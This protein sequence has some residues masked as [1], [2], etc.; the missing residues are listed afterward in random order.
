LK[1]QKVTLQ[2]WF[3]EKYADAWEQVM[4]NR[5]F[6]TPTSSVRYSVGQPMGFYSSWAVFALTHHA[7]VEFAAHRKG[8]RSFRDYSLLGDDIV[9]WNRDVAIEYKKLLHELG[10]PFSKEKSLSSDDQTIRVEFAKRFFL[11]GEEITPLNPNIIK[12]ASKSIYDLLLLT[13]V[14]SGRGW[15]WKEADIHAPEFLSGKGKKLLVLLWHLL[16]VR[17]CP[18]FKGVT[19]NL[20]DRELIER[21][22]NKLRLKM[23]QRKLV[24]YQKI[25]ENP[26]A[27]EDILTSRGV[28]LSEELSKTFQEIDTPYP[29]VWVL[30]DIEQSLAELQGNLLY[31]EEGKEIS[32][33][34]ADVEFLPK[35]WIQTFY[36]SR[37]SEFRIRSSTWLTALL[38]LQKDQE[39]IRS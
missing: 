35:P 39:V 26:K 20:P 16:R 32:E 6:H 23:L 5:E 11:N 38:N 21:E 13:K 27:L 1:L 28:L 18:P 31:P 37:E 15:R 17:W 10:I 22:F 2:I 19:P 8:F 33:I 7:F 29:L 3:G 34:L 9:I 14:M 25:I 30:G 12:A 24:E 36:P 4:V